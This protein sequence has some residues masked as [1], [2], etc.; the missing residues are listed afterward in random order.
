[1]NNKVIAVT[2]ITVGYQVEI[3]SRTSYIKKYT[4]HEDGISLVNLEHVYKVSPL[5]NYIVDNESAKHYKSVKGPECFY[6]HFINGEKMMCGMKDYDAVVNAF[7]GQT[8]SKKCNRNCTK[9]EV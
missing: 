3:F 8:S 1:M 2:E 5:K 4:V 6:I 9:K 7:T